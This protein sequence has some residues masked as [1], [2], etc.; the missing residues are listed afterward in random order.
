MFSATFP[1]NVE[2]LAKTILRKPL[3]IVVGVRG[4]TCKN[5]TQLIEIREETSKFFRILELLGI[6]E[7]KGQV[8]I[9]VD[10]QQDADELFKKILFKQ[11]KPCLLH[12]GQDVVD[13]NYTL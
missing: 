13:R 5:V 3:E 7:D 8:L 9:F 12:G 1:R 11:Y 2:V 10:R 6:W 4:Q